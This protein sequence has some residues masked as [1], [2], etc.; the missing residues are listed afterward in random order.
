MDKEST[1]TTNVYMC[2]VGLLVI[3]SG[4]CDD[5]ACPVGRFVERSPAHVKTGL[6]GRSPGVP[7]CY[8]AITILRVATRAPAG[9]DLLEDTGIPWSKKKE[10]GKHTSRT[11]KRTPATRAPAHCIQSTMDDPPDVATL[12]AGLIADSESARKYAVFKLQGLLADPSFADAFI[13]GDGLPALRLCVLEA[14]GNAQAYALGSLLVL[15]ELDMGWEIVDGEVVEKVS[16]Y[17][18]VGKS[19]DS[20]AVGFAVTG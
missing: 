11:G 8:T 15:L 6:F 20:D 13:Q 5:T 17:D 14:G 2:C 1:C 3:R 12:V 7:Y 10:P 18:V 4:W 19:W 9:L 16:R